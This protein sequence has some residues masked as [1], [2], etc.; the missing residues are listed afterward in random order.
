MAL[1]VIQAPPPAHVGQAE[2]V[3]RSVPTGLAE[4]VV[5]IPGTIGDLRQLGEA[6]AQWVLSKI[7]DMGGQKGAKIG[8]IPL[9]GALNPSLPVRALGGAASLAMQKMGVDPRLARLNAAALVPS[10]AMAIA[11]T[12]GQIMG[13]LTKDKPL[14]QPQT[15]AGKYAKTIASFAPAALG[16][17]GPVR[18]AAMVVVPAVASEAA[19]QAT[20]GTPYE[21]AARVAAAIL[22]GGGVSA[23]GNGG[24][25]TRLISEASRGATDEQ[26]QA[27]RTLMEQGQEHG[28]RL[29]MAEA[30][31]QVT[32]GATGM[33][34]MQRVVEGTKAGNARIAPVMAER[35]AQVRGAVTG[36]A[37]Q[38]AAPTNQPSMLGAQA[39]ET[40]ETALD[41]VR[42][43]INEQAAPHYDRLQRYGLS[44]AV[45]RPLYEDPAYLQ[46]AQQV[47]QNPVLGPSLEHLPDG[48]PAFINEVVKWLD[49]AAENA[50][51]GAMNPQ[52]NNQLAAAYTR[53]ASSA[54]QLMTDFVPDW[55]Q[56]RQTVSQGRAANLEPLQ[57]GPLGA[58]AATGDVGAQ[59]KALFPTQPLEGAPDETRLAIEMMG[60]SA[61][62]PARGLVR[63]HLVN[64]ANE[65]MQQNA[66]GP[67]QW[68]GAKWAAAIAGNPEQA[69]TLQAGVRAGGG[70]PT[71]LDRLLEVMRAT[72][73]RQPPGSMTAYNA[74]DLEELGKAGVL[75]ETLRTGLNPPGIFRR[76]GEFF[77]NWQTERNADQLAR[78]LLANPADAERI[79]MHARQVVPEGQGLQ[80]IERL[81][82]AAR[83]AQ[84]PQLEAS[85]AP[86]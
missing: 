4:G 47:R 66:G 49:N 68:G 38:I 78:D 41:G 29:T 21:G 6:G 43:G 9:P 56:A 64:T 70:D 20:E 5:S 32:E 42:R 18:K 84:Q 61:S 73:K 25:P 35:P 33:G 8:P 81:A 69:A 36:L 23:L 31:Q 53:A 86:R 14:Y 54:R 27:A 26:I 50:R 80:T 76:A 37:D 63:Q 10:D 13:G 30:L 57:R 28:V 58:I 71:T 60:G 67:N 2:D 77:Q 7:G 74:K 16:P 79:L 82:I 12:S 17:G 15:K 40:A 44:D 65:A 85:G 75:G 24:A 46:A 83:L 45:I 1:R 19:G 51:P 22:A 59:T 11:P 39:Q 72:G 34:R 62:D 52:G 3:A 48:N 55:T